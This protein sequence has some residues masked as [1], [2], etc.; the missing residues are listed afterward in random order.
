MTARPSCIFD[1]VHLRSVNMDQAI[2]F[3]Q[4]IFKALGHDKSL[5]TGRDWLEV[6]GFYLGQ[7]DLGAPPSRIHLAFLARSRAEVDAFHA[8]GL[9]GGGRDNGGPGWRD[10]HPG[11]YAAYLLDPDDNNIE[12]KFDER[13][14]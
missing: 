6:D 4:A 10:Y 8:A 13:T 12:A 2:G 3:Y 9:E 11:Y 7:A 5:R 14:G 1:H